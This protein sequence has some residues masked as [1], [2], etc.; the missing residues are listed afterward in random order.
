MLSSAPFIGRETVFQNPF[1]LFWWFVCCKMEVNRKCFLWSTWNEFVFFAKKMFSESALIPHHHHYRYSSTTTLQPATNT[2]IAASIIIF[3]IGTCYQ[4]KEI[5]LCRKSVPHWTVVLEKWVFLG[6]GVGG[7]G[8][9]WNQGSISWN[10][11]WKFPR[12]ITM[13]DVGNWK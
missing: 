1:S 9:M 12:T 5:A 3:R 2:T 7:V 10:F 11:R 4:T 6:A 8:R 13:Q